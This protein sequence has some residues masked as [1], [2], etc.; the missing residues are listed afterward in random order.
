MVFYNECTFQNSFFIPFFFPSN[1]SL[2]SLWY[3]KADCPQPIFIK[4]ISKPLSASISVFLDLL[5]W[6][7]HPPLGHTFY[8]QGV[9]GQHKLG[10]HTGYVTA[11]ERDPQTLQYCSVR[12]LIVIKKTKV[13]QSFL[14]ILYQL[15]KDRRKIQNQYTLWVQQAVLYL[16]AQHL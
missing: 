2:M 6:T 13:E 14:K 10:S 15:A 1:P 5:T 12:N 8:E 4:I 3:P 16:L 7:R 9:Q 11:P